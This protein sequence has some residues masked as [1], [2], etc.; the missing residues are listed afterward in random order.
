MLYAVQLFAPVCNVHAVQCIIANDDC[1]SYIDVFNVIVKYGQRVK[2]YKAI[3]VRS[4]GYFIDARGE[5]TT[6]GIV[7][8][9]THNER[10]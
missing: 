7:T 9:T 2:V 4:N 5:P 10:H 1:Y 6:M 8:I 3:K